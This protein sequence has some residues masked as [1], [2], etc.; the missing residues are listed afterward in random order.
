VHSP[1][2]ASEKSQARDGRVR[3][4]EEVRQRGMSRTAL[5]A[6]LAERLRNP[7]RSGPR[8]S[9]PFETDA[10]ECALETLRARE[11]DG[12]LGVDDLVDGEIACVSGLGEMLL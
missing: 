3:A 1:W 11:P 4:D 8:Q 9:E 6:V 10:L 2:I 5:A 7:P 12:D